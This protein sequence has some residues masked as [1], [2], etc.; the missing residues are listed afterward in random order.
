MF[1]WFWLTYGM[2]RRYIIIFKKKKITLTHLKGQQ[3]SAIS[4]E[5]KM[6][7]SLSIWCKSCTAKKWE[8]LYKNS[9]GK[10]TGC[11][12]EQIPFHWNSLY[13]DGQNLRKTRAAVG[14]TL[15]S[16]NHSHTSWT[17]KHISTVL[18]NQKRNSPNFSELFKTNRKMHFYFVS[19]CGFIV[20]SRYRRPKMWLHFWIALSNPWAIASMCSIFYW[21][22]PRWAQFCWVIASLFPSVLPHFTPTRCPYR[23]LILPM[24]D[25]VR[26]EFNDLILTA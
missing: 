23:C 17:E 18:L 9:M 6:F 24:S 3:I 4:Q 10:K 12:A 5:L 13:T 2:K 1:W 20:D 25:G 16:Y 8:R 26:G 7:Y 22:A 11:Q 21:P 15:F 14:D 19:E